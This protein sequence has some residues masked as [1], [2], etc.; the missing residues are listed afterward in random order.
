MDNLILILSL[1]PGIGKKSVSYFIDNVQVR[2]KNTQDII[3]AFTQ[4]KQKNTRIVIPTIDNINEAIT[5]K[6]NVLSISKHYDVNIVDKT[7]ENYPSKLKN[8]KDAPNILFYKGNYNAV[9]NERSITIIG[10]RRASTKAKEISYEVARYFAKEGYTII[11]GLA[12]GCDEYAHKG[13]LR[14]NGSTVAVLASGLNQ[15]YPLTNKELAKQIINNN[16]CL[17][18]EYPIGTKCYRHNFVERDRIQSGLSSATLVIETH[19][20]SGTMHTVKY[21]KEQNRIL[22]CY[23]INTEGN[24]TLISKNGCMAIY[25]NKD[26]KT[27]IDKI[28]TYKYDIDYQIKF[29]L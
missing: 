28:N 20:D 17:V 18:S 23:G 27:L 24:N 7:S 26:I 10:S 11:S 16:G 19:L 4:L 5:K 2:P 13:T 3:E 25:N 29:D 14:E 22:A 12:L 15:I 6:N 8:I 21:A 9:V 1:I